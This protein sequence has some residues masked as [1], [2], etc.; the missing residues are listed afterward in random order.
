MGTFMLLSL[1]TTVAGGNELEFRDMHQT[2]GQ[3]RHRVISILQKSSA[4]RCRST[5]AVCCDAEFPRGQ[6]KVVRFEPN[7]C[8]TRVDGKDSSIVCTSQAYTHQV[9]CAAD[10]Q[11][12]LL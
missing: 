2:S 3:E 7:R 9:C 5:S 11:A 12:Q 10:L 6:S 4:L 8:H 1:Q